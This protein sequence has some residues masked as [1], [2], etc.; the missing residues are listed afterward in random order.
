MIRPSAIWLWD[1]SATGY[2]DLTNNVK[3]NTAFNFLENSDD[4]VYFGLDKRFIGFLTDLSINGVYTGLTFEYQARD[5][6]WHSLSLIDAYAFNRSR[7]LRW[8]LPEDWIKFNFT[9]T[10]PHGS[11][12]PDTVER[13][14]IRMKCTGVST[15]AVISKLRLLPYATYTS[16]DKVTKMLSFKFTLNPSSRPSDL[17]VE[18]LIRRA[19][20]RIDYVTYKSWRFNA[21]SEEQNI[22]PTLQD[23]NRY[24]VFPRH[25]NIFKVYNLTIWD[26][27]QWHQMNEGR[28]NDYFVDYD[29]GMIYFTRLFLLPAAYGMVG[30][31]FHWGFGE[32]KM[33]VKIDYVYGRDLETDRQFH[34]V[35]DICT[36]QV[37][38]DM[39][40]HHD[41][42]KFIVSGTDKVPL[43]RKIEMMQKEIDDKLEELKAV[44]MW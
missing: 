4:Y 3:T 17:D 14:W 2:V 34:I 31:Y 35:E 1:V 30:R 9:D 25:R 39:L 26:G 23:Y 16:P 42:S 29:R 36:K 5:A 18:D 8:V 13:Y 6:T 12:A 37:A 40:R 21:V 38:C 33:S 44:T 15:T 11:G 32:F 19:E 28:Q 22:D 7:Y 43:E 41:Y 27:G 24:G 20:D 10:V